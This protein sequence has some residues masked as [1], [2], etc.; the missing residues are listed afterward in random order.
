MKYTVTVNGT[1]IVVEID[2]EKARVGESSVR[3]RLVDIDGGPERILR[4]GDEVHR[5]FVRSGET[6]G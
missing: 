5:V 4:R 2:G 6:R 1:D 3:A